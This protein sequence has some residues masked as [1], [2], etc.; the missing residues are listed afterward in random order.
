MKKKQRFRLGILSVLG[1]FIVMGLAAQAGAQVFDVNDDGKTGVP[2]AIYSLKTAAGIIVDYDRPM[3]DGYNTFIMGVVVD[4]AGKPVVGAR[5]FVGDIETKTNSGGQYFLKDVPIYMEPQQARSVELSEDSLNQMI[6]VSVIPPEDTDLT[7]ALISVSTSMINITQSCDQIAVWLDEHEFDINDYCS[8]GECSQSFNFESIC[9]GQEDCEDQIFIAAD[10]DLCVLPHKAATVK[11]VVRNEST[12]EA[13]VGTLVSARFVAVN[14]D[15]LVAPGV[16]PAE[17]L[18]GL[19][20]NWITETPLVQFETNE[21]GGFELSGL[22]TSSEYVIEVDGYSGASDC[23]SD[24]EGPCNRPAVYMNTSPYNGGSYV[25]NAGNIYVSLITSNDGVEP[26]LN[27]TTT[28]GGISY[29]GVPIPEHYGSGSMVVYSNNVDG[30]AGN[31]FQISFSEEIAQHAADA[32][33]SESVSLIKMADGSAIEVTR[34]FMDGKTLKIQTTEPVEKNTPL[35][36]KLK[37][38]HFI[39]G[40]GNQLAFSEGMA[41]SY[42][43]ITGMY[44]VLNASTDIDE[45]IYIN[46]EEPPTIIKDFSLTPYVGF[47]NAEFEKTLVVYA[48]GIDGTTGKEFVIK[49]SEP[50]QEDIADLNSVVLYSLTES[51]ALALDSVNIVGDTLNITTQEAVPNDSVLEFRLKRSDFLDP[52]G[53]MIIRSRAVPCPTENDNCTPV[54]ETGECSPEEEYSEGNIYLVLNACTDFSALVGPGDEQAP[55]LVRNR[56][57]TPYTKIYDSEQERYMVVF[58]NGI[59]G[60][61]KAFELNFS[62]ILDEEA[63]SIDSVSMYSLSDSMTIGISQV[64]LSGNT[65]KIITESEVPKD[66][67]LDIILKRSDFIDLSGNM[68]IKS[69]AEECPLTETCA[70]ECEDHECAPEEV[71]SENTISLILQA[72]TDFEEPVI[73]DVVP[74]TIIIN[75]E[76]TPYTI[77]DDVI[78]GDVL[79]YADGIYGNDREFE[80]NFSEILNEDIVNNDS[81]FLRDEDT[82]LPIAI[83]EVT[84]DGN[85]LRIKTAADLS[86]DTSFTIRLKR[87]DFTDL[88]GNRIDNSDLTVDHLDDEFHDMY[89]IINV[90]TERDSQSHFDRED[91]VIDFEGNEDIANLGIEK[92]DC[93]TLMVY[94]D[95]INGTAGNEFTLKFSEPLK[96]NIITLNSLILYNISDSSI[97]N[98]TGVELIAD[99]LKITTEALDPDTVFEIRLKRS[100][101][102]DLVGKEIVEND[103]HEEDS[104]KFQDQYLAICAST[105]FVTDYDDNDENPELDL[106]ACDFAPVTTTVEVDDEDKQVIVYDD[107]IDGTDGNAFEVK[108]NEP[109]QDVDILPVGA[110]ILYDVENNKVIEEG[111]TASISENTLKITTDEDIEGVFEIRLKRDAFVDPYGN[112]LS[113]VES[114][115]TNDLIHNVSIDG[116]PEGESSYLVLNA[117]TYFEVIPK[118]DLEPLPNVAQ[119]KGE[120]VDLAGEPTPYSNPAFNS[121]IDYE[122]GAGNSIFN[123]NAANAN[124]EDLLLLAQAI[125]QP[126]DNN[127]PSAINP[128]VAQI[129]FIPDDEIA[130][131][132]ITAM[133]A[134]GDEINAN[135][136]DLSDEEKKIYLV[137]MGGRRLAEGD[138]VV[139]QTINDFG[140]IGE[141]VELELRDNTPITTV[142]NSDTPD[143][144]DEVNIFPGTAPEGFGGNLVDVGEGATGT[145]MPYLYAR[146][147][148]LKFEYDDTDTDLLD[149]LKANDD[150]LYN[151]DGFASFETERIIGIQISEPPADTIVTDIKAL[152]NEDGEEI[153]DEVFKITKAEALTIDDHHI[154]A[155]TVNNIFALQDVFSISL[156]GLKDAAGNA[157]CSKAGVKVQDLMPPLMSEAI[158]EG[159][160]VIFRFSEPVS[161]AKDRN[162]NEIPEFISLG[163]A[164]TFKTTDNG[165][166]AVSKSVPYVGPNGETIDAG[167][168]LAMDFDPETA[169]GSAGV[170]T[171][172]LNGNDENGDDTGADLGCFFSDS[173]EGNSVNFDHVPDLHYNIWVDDDSNVSDNLSESP[174]FAAEDHVSQAINSIPNPI[175]PINPGADQELYLQIVDINGNL[176]NT[177]DGA[178]AATLI[179]AEEALADTEEALAQAITD[180]N[181]AGNN[182]TNAQAEGVTANTNLNTAQNAADAAAQAVTSTQNAADAAAQAVTNITNAVD[183]L[184]QQLATAQTTADAAAQAVT[185]AQTDLD[186]AQ[187][188]L[189]QAIAE[190]LTQT[191]IDFLEDE[192]DQAQQAV[193]DAQ[194]DLDTANQQLDQIQ[195]NYDNA[196]DALTQAEAEAVTAN[197]NLTN[198]QAEFDTAVDNLAEAQD[199]FDAAAQAVIDAQTALSTAQEARND[200]GIARDAAETARNNA[201]TALDQEAEP[202]WAVGFQSSDDALITVRIQF[203][204]PVEVPDDAMLSNMPDSYTPGAIIAF[205]VRGVEVEFELKSMEVVQEGDAFTIPAGS[206][207]DTAGNPLADDVVITLRP[208]E[209]GIIVEPDT[210]Y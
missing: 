82:D 92:P 100:D 191:V 128:N 169:D 195:D 194:T 83:E 75:N 46:D 64:E 120:N 155:A 193:T 209:A 52:A 122:R 133:D 148:M 40:A 121:V 18:E 58:A 26:T 178:S 141:A 68:L 154:V 183:Q 61:N 108:F 48:K 38:A 60:V 57:I 105:Y 69:R 124:I 140:D 159:D 25:L 125:D 204:E 37:R 166:V 156:E 107:G 42:T 187:Q 114:D 185:D 93:C 203:R 50:L 197:A 150:G 146:A 33:T 115:E 94:K 97:I 192:R 66:N 71:Y 1:L 164:Y 3:P 168:F 102:V 9:C 87:V 23:G 29:T 55:T 10:V 47:F 70:P 189:D 180:V 19:Q 14:L 190:G 118:L 103:D 198:A 132:D 78:D 142:I 181:T 175:T 51:R 152:K 35:E 126:A 174:K 163:T 76:L 135:I 28:I 59:D 5:V 106:M 210:V 17:E 90:S 158:I 201:L 99:T 63:V 98:V 62:E 167:T 96:D 112:A 44:L 205:D 171:L 206:I 27:L 45:S 80:I 53:N 130:D 72:R 91:P 176:L 143:D 73:G 6:I 131:Y 208:A 113:Q 149:E 186:G 162:I 104:Y 123:L 11:G 188:T 136:Q 139:V 199:A 119:D 21:L 160:Q 170:L 172:T 196:N 56:D 74:P 16:I 65:L 81:V 41:E 49:F 134:E 30:T 111:I 145:F 79:V 179:A 85:T 24:N 109:L 77:Y 147:D 43:S 101:F 2:E 12:G 4:D 34:V 137:N 161:L 95:G 157:A 22:L 207:K 173:V 127:S 138:H 7:S 177:R 144:E 117:S 151:K 15:T 88:A 31:E 13:I 67:I 200:A 129:S 202:N 20:F 32:L 153:S 110:V 165:I 84:L 86:K 184:T 182:L 39:D 116:D 54:C 8:G 36:I 89:L